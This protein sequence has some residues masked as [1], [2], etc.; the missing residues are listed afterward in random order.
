[1]IYMDNAATTCMC[2][3]AVQSMGPYLNEKFENPSAVYRRSS[4]IKLD[5]YDARSEIAKLINSRPEE[6]FFTS[7]GTEADNWALET[8]AFMAMEKGNLNPSII[9]TKIEHHAI[10]HTCEF[11]ER[12]G[13]EITYLNVDRYGQVDPEDVKSSIKENTV[14]VSIMTAN[15]EIG[16]IEPVKEIAAICHEKGVL[17]HTDA[18]QAVGHIRIDV[19]DMD[20]DLLS[21]SAHKLYGPKGIGFLYIKSGIKFGAFIHGGEQERD[22]RAGTEN[23]PAIIGFGAAAKFARKTLDERFE[24]ET[25]L[26]NYMIEK[27]LGEISDTHLNGAP[28][29]EKNM[30]LPGNINITFNNISAESLLISLDMEDIMASAGSACSAGAVEPSHVL[31]AIGLDEGS[32]RSTLRFSLGKDNTRDDVDKTVLALKLI[33]EEIR[34]KG[35]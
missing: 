10:L 33:C 11:L 8:A 5:I 28:C 12:M 7:G 27:I 26:R 24:K 34:N 15:N 30:R 3:E 2:Q 14:L 16:T 35:K 25:R 21:C 13:C 1:M 4:D 29:I 17:F 6:I 32:V 23:V 19:A 20:P 18:V 9:T 22:R 31:T